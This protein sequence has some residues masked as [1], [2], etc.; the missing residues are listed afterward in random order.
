MLRKSELNSLNNHGKNQTLIIRPKQPYSFRE[1][2]SSHGWV[3]LEPWSWDDVNDILL[4]TETLSSG[5]KLN[6]LI[7]VRR[8]GDISV[9]YDCP[10]LLENDRKDLK[11][12]IR[13]A[14][15]LNWSPGHVIQLANRLSPPV[16][17]FLKMGGGRFLRGTTFYEDFVKTICTLNTNWQSTQ[18]MARSLS[19]L[20]KL[21]F[22]TPRTILSFG[23]RELQKRASL[24]Y[25]AE[26]LDAATKILLDQGLMDEVGRR[27]NG[28]ISYETLIGI[29]GLGPYAASHLR[30]LQ[31]DFSCLPI[32]SEVARYCQEYLGLEAKRINK[33]FEQW[34]EYIFL[35]YKLN[36]ILL[37]KNWIG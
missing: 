15:T 37:R 32:D 23:S 13:R 26:I 12:R 3:N 18:R 8:N 27:T 5:L 20:V 29:K 21:G 30:M 31:L 9:S 33:H 11:E 1:T 19:D 36:R 28:D 4:R 35:G 7:K 14:L 10:K 2:V 25:R 6:L 34:G 16:A 24:G 22:P 17:R